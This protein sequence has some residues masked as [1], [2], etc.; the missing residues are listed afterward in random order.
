MK[1]SVVSQWPVLHLLQGMSWVLFQ[2]LQC[3]IFVPKTLAIEDR[4]NLLQ[5]F[6]KKL[7][8]IENRVAWFLSELC[9]A[10]KGV[11]KDKRNHSAGQSS[12][13]GVY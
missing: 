3:K 13:G 12:L 7:K 6:W 2:L 1:C 10:E 8:N 5:F 9:K 4:Q 11:P